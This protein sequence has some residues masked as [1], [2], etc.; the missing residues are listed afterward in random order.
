[1]ADMPVAFSPQTTMGPPET[2]ERMARL[3]LF[4]LTNRTRD[5]RIIAPENLFADLRLSKPASVSG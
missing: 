2:T 4:S 3:I 5:V 1:M